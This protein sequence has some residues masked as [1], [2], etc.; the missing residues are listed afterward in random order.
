MLIFIIA[1][2]EKETKNQLQLKAFKANSLKK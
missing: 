1:G 2:I